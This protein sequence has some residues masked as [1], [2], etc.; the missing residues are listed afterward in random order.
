M[1]VMG[2]L[3]EMLA[4]LFIYQRLHFLDDFPLASFV[5]VKLKIKALLEFVAGSYT[6]GLISLVRLFDL[7]EGAFTL[8][9]FF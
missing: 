9:E 5:M 7:I 8:G 4:K 3:V 6:F 1:C 2:C